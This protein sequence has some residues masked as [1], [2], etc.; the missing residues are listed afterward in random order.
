MKPKPI[1][2][3]VMPVLNPHP[4]YFRQAVESILNQTFEDWELVIV[5]DPSPHP[6][7]DILKDY[8]DKR[9]RHILNSQRTSSVQQRN[10]GLQ[11][12]IGDLIAC[13][14]HDDFSEPERLE[15]QV[16]FMTK[17]PQIAVVGT[18]LQFIDEEGRT[19]GF[20]CYP[21]EHA[22]IVRSMRRFNPIGHSSAMF[23]RQV[24]LK[25]GGYQNRGF[26]NDYDLWCRI[27]KGGYRFANLPKPLVHRRIHRQMLTMSKLKAI[28]R[29]TI[30][31][32]RRY[33]RDE[34]D[35]GDN[36]RLIIERILMLFPITF[37]NWL[38]L[39]TQLKR[40]L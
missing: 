16:E 1:V 15:E 27:A 34:M 23:L 25:C 33:W 30:E 26:V 11:E 24:V 39:K 32:K 17:N 38:F 40:R 20:R 7:N 4:V 5:E 3:V 21:C 29:D 31:T 14:D 37:V 28:I 22:D 8:K 18:W 19:I 10:R 12:A 2:S 9:I 6:A 13:H 35:Y 36:L